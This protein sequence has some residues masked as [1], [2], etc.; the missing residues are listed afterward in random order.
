MNERTHQLLRRA[1]ECIE[2]ASDVHQLELNRIASGTIAVGKLGAALRHGR[3]I[4][5]LERA[6]R[7]LAGILDQPPGLGGAE[8]LRLLPRPD[9]P[10]R[11]R[12]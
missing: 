9:R 11:E 10:D 12:A 5:T 4:D 3:T 1:L 7:D 2:L 8:P 6:A